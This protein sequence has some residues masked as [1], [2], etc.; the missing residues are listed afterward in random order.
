MSFEY[1]DSFISSGWFTPSLLISKVSHTSPTIPHILNN[2][3]L[4]YM[5]IDLD[6]MCDL[7]RGCV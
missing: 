1:V 6:Q 3:I 7:M 2:Y 4:N 5:N